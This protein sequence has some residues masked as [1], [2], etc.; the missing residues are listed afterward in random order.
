MAGLP[1][2]A[3]SSSRCPR[4][5]ALPSSPPRPIPSL[6]SDPDPSA[7]CE[8]PARPSRDAA[9]GADVDGA[10]RDVAVNG[11]SAR[12]AVD[13]GTPPPPTLDDVVGGPVSACREAG[14]AADCE[15]RAAGVP[16]AATV[17]S[18]IDRNWGGGASPRGAPSSA[19]TV[20]SAGHGLLVRRDLFLPHGLLVCVVAVRVVVAALVKRADRGDGR[21]GS[22]PPRCS[23]WASSC[24]RPLERL[25]RRGA[26]CRPAHE[27][28]L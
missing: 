1:V 3:A 26:S 5:L 20:S 28:A 13:G 8:P 7:A 6:V 16:A 10:A 17:P 18:P 25:K 11:A 14:L 2:A 23:R 9:I 4:L 21:M 24:S 19:R 27:V 15:E 12:R 22:R